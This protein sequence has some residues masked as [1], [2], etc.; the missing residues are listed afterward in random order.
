MSAPTAI[1]IPLQNYSTGLANYDAMIVT[2]SAGGVTLESSSKS[3]G[4]ALGAKDI[5]FN[6]GYVMNTS[7]FTTPSSD[8]GAG[9]SYSGWFWPATIQG[10]D[11]LVYVTVNTTSGSKVVATP[12]LQI[13]LNTTGAPTGKAWVSANYRGTTITTSDPSSAAVPRTWNFFCFTVECSGSVAAMSLHTN[14]KVYAATGTAPAYV[15]ETWTANY[16]AAAGSSGSNQFVGKMADM[17]SFN[18][19]M[20]PME[21]SVLY[22]YY[23]QNM[24]GGTPLAASLNVLALNTSYN[25]NGTMAANTLTLD[26]Q[27]VFSYIAVQRTPP[28]AQGAATQY[29]SA[30]Q[31]QHVSGEWVWTDASYNSFAPALYSLVPYAMGVQAAKGVMCATPAYIYAVTFSGAQN[32]Q[33]SFYVAGSYN[34]MSIYSGTRLLVSGLTYV[35][36]GTA[37]YIDAN[38]ANDPSNV[39]TFYPTNYQMMVGAPASIRVPVLNQ[40]TTSI[41]ESIVTFT[42]T[43]NYTNVT[44]SRGTTLLTTLAQSTT[45]YV[46]QNYTNQSSYIYNFVPYY[47]PLYPGATV[48]AYT[49]YITNVT[50]TPGSGSIGFVITG[51]Y[52]S[53]YYNRTSPSNITVSSSLITDTSCQDTSVLNITY[54]YTFIPVGADGTTVGPGFSLSASPII[55]TGAANILMYGQANYPPIY[56]YDGLYWYKPQ[57]PSLGNANYYLITANSGSAVLPGG[58]S[59]IVALNYYEGSPYKFQGVYTSPDNVTWTA[60]N[61]TGIAN[62]IYY[63]NNYA[64]ASDGNSTFVVLYIG[65][66]P[67]IGPSIIGNYYLNGDYTTLNYCDVCGGSTYINAQFSPTSVWY[68]NNTWMAVGSG[69]YYTKIGATLTKVTPNAVVVKSTDGIHWYNFIPITTLSNTSNTPSGL[70]TLRFFSKLNLQGTQYTNVWIAGTGGVSSTRP[71]FIFSSDNGTTWSQLFNP[72]MNCYTNP[73]TLTTAV[74]STIPAGRVFDIDSDGNGLNFVFTTDG[75]PTFYTTDGFT[76]IYKSINVP[77]IGTNGLKFAGFQQADPNVVAI[78]NNTYPT[79]PNSLTVGQTVGVFIIHTSS[80][81]YFSV[82]NGRD[83]FIVPSQTTQTLSSWPN[84]NTATTSD[85]ACYSQVTLGYSN[86]NP[87]VIIPFTTT[88]GSQYTFT[89]SFASFKFYGSFTSIKVERSDGATISP[90]TSIITNNPVTYLTF[91]DSNISRNTTYTYTF[92]PYYGTLIKGTAQTVTIQTQW[93]DLHNMGP[94]SGQLSGGNSGLTFNG[95]VPTTAA[96]NNLSYSTVYDPISQYLWVGG[97]FNVS[98]NTIYS[99]NIMYYDGTVWNNVSIPNLSIYGST[100]Q[101]ASNKLSLINGNIV[102]AVN[103]VSYASGILNYKFPPTASSLPTIPSITS[104]GTFIWYN[105]T[106]YSFASSNVMSTQICC[107]DRSGRCWG[108]NNGAMQYLVNTGYTYLNNNIPYLSTWSP[109][110]INTTTPGTY[111]PASITNCCYN[112]KNDIMYGWSPGTSSVITAFDNGGGTGRYGYILYFSLTATNVPRKVG[113]GCNGVV[114]SGYYDYNTNTFYV[115]GS[116]SN[117]GGSTIMKGVGMSVT[118]SGTPGALQ[119]LGGGLGLYNQTSKGNVANSDFYQVNSVVVNSNTGVV[120]VGGQFTMACNLVNGTPNY[121]TTLNI[122]QFTFADPNNPSTSAGTW[123]SVGTGLTID[124]GTI[125]YVSQLYFDPINND[126]YAIGKFTVDGMGNPMY[127]LAKTNMAGYVPNMKVLSITPNG[128]AVTSD[129]VS[130]TVL[131]NGYGSTVYNVY[132]FQPAY[133]AP[134]SSATYTV[135]YTCTSPRTI[136]IFAVGGGGGGGNAIGGG[137]GGGQVVMSSVTLPSTGSGG[138][139]IAVTVGGGGVRGSGPITTTITSYSASYGGGQG[140]S[141]SVTFNDPTLSSSSITAAG[142]G[143][144][145][146]NANGNGGAGASG[147]GAA[148][149]P[150]NLA[151]SAGAGTSGQGYNGGAAAKTGSAPF[152]DGNLFATG[153]GGGGAGSAANGPNGGNGVQINATT[154]PIIADFHPNSIPYRTYYWGGGGG[155]GGSKFDQSY[156]SSNLKGGKGG[157]GGGSYDFNGGFNAAGDTDTSLTNGGNGKMNEVQANQNN[158]YAYSGL[159]GNGGPNTGG[160]GGGAYNGIPGNG[161]SGIVILAFPQT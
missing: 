138:N 23:R 82:N 27:S 159:G 14:G 36:L 2:N 56:S 100:I 111:G 48:Q 62:L 106:L 96:A 39:Y 7:P 73:T 121:V 31:V 71:H 33:I 3:G 109:Y 142:G 65:G 99:N 21:I 156:L 136:Y 66:M 22:A 137:G 124:T 10:G 155:G 15:E 28:F 146:A 104:M 110:A 89:A 32:G 117:D 52:A 81:I 88:G 132:S 134:G 115:A 157:G 41:S 17:R 91:T 120:Y 154:S 74:Y 149:F 93:D 26:P 64:T 78:V 16:L 94:S 11:M 98:S 108:V 140:L 13:N 55:P 76:T 161:G 75:R 29:V 8:D 90:I 70:Q 40:V 152:R 57:T 125:S 79:G 129:V 45:T 86:T 141:S 112:G 92:T 102:V 44:I 37:V 130:G 67:S 143:G 84:K 34:T 133:L 60:Q 35:P 103:R 83:W 80:V 153:G 77:N 85:R 58:Q 147:G 95:F 30:A 12:V 148:G 145:G 139:T 144:G 43:G 128:G 122:A 47:D 5:S 116:F 42:M 69:S 54:S 150:L 135:T 46:V 127:N 51:N 61:S 59:G 101:P 151:A 87:P 158:I 25:A 97:G 24:K 68:A 6:Q 19:V 107:Y 105:G 160:G 4:S 9:V 113:N 119:A 126:L 114:N 18:R 123:S 50:A 20:R 49:P 131:Q 63:A 72:S 118:S 1:T 53:F 38:I